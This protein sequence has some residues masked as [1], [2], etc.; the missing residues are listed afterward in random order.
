M[1]ISP[2]IK[3]S[4]YVNQ[5]ISLEETSMDFRPQ[6]GDQRRAFPPNYAI[7][8]EIIKFTNKAMLVVLGLGTT[9]S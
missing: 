8:L 4:I 9:H 1:T 7:C 6:S 2:T 3:L 5:I